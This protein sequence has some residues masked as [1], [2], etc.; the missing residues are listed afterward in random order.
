[1]DFIGVSPDMVAWLLLGYVCG[2]SGRGS[3]VDDLVRRR[4][5]G[6]RAPQGLGVPDDTQT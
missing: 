4:P 5:G 3:L 2:C 1:M 6:L